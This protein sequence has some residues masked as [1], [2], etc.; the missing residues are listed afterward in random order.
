M[1]YGRKRFR[2]RSTKRRFRFRGR[3][4]FGKSF[5]YRKRSTRPTRKVFKGTTVSDEIFAKVNLV[6]LHQVSINANQT[7]DVYTV[8]GNS[9]Y[10]PSGATEYVLGVQQF[11][12]FYQR[13]LVMACKLTAT[14]LVGVD[15]ADALGEI[16][17]LPST[18]A[19][20]ANIQEP[21][22]QKYH[23]WT[24]YGNTTGS[25]SV[26]R[27]KHFMSAKKIFGKAIS[28]ADE[29]VYDQPIAPATVGGAT[30]DPSRLWYWHFIVNNLTGPLSTEGTTDLG[31]LRIKV[32]YWVKYLKRRDI[33]EQPE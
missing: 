8:K 18:E 19:T 13:V 30:A 25:K 22:E 21:A 17:L 6:S 33:I 2:P 15:Q 5:R 28:A 16:I 26:V 20:P 1:P 3:R 14:L 10:Q 7:Q 27:M 23:K 12:G 31:I 29:G 32:T 4:R 11:A 9:L 24:A